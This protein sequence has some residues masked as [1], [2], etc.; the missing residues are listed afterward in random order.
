MPTLAEPAVLIRSGARRGHTKIDWLEAWHSFNSGAYREP[1]NGHFGLLLVSNDDVIQPGRGFG[2]HPH[3]DLEIITWPVAGR[4]A[5]HDSEGNRGELRPGQIQQMTAG[6]GIV[7]SEMNP[8]A[9]DTARWVQMWV[10]PD[11]PR[12]QPRYQDIDVSGA[13]S[14]GELV[15]IVGRRHADTLADHNQRDAVFWAARLPA[16]RS[17]L[18]PDAPRV[19]CY[20]T[21]G[22]VELEGSAVLSAGDAA[23]LSAAGARRLTATRSG[24]A[25]VLVWEMHADLPEQA[26]RLRLASDSR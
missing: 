22:A 4:V 16:G 12:L 19:H 5:H 18:L 2:E 21:A 26:E 6:S 15:P 14:S 1:G 7:H 11:T 10:L 17:A 23:R 3:R 24:P 20:V 13:L 25:E 8:S 9:T